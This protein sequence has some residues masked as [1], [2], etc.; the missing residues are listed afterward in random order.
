MPQW[1][2]PSLEGF[3]GFLLLLSGLAIVGHYIYGDL[4]S[5]VAFVG[6]FIVYALV[7]EFVWKNHPRLA[8]RESWPAYWSQ[9]WR[10]ILVGMSIFLLVILI[11]LLVGTAEIMSIR[12]DFVFG[13]ALVAL[14]TILEIT[15]RK[16]P[17]LGLN[18]RPDINQ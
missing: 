9:A 18:S 3:A 16:K 1:E 7:G 11:E 10:E 4:G 14:G 2:G 17:P 5:L 15:G 13:M 8:W 6:T 12:Y